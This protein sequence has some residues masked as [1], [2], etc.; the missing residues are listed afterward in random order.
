MPP[1]ARPRRV[2]AP[3][4]DGRLSSARHD[5]L[6]PLGTVGLGPHVLNQIGFLASTALIAAAGA[7]VFGLLGLV[8]ATPLLLRLSRRFGSCGYPPSSWPVSPRC[9]WR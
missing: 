9:S 4:P 3:P 2:A 8:A 1:A 5:V 6:G 7:A